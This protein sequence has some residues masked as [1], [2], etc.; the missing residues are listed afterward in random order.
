MTSQQN[1]TQPQANRGNVNASDAVHDEPPPS[2]T[3]IENIPEKRVRRERTVCGGC[4]PEHTAVMTIL[5]MYFFLS[6][7]YAGS[8]AVGI[9]VLTST[10]DRI[11]YAISLGLSV[12][13][14]VTSLIG[15]NV[16]R[17]KKAR[18]LKHLSIAFWVLTAL[19]LTF[20]ASFFITLIVIREKL[21][22]SCVEQAA[23][24]GDF[25]ALPE[26]KLAVNLRIIRDAFSLFFIETLQLYFAYVIF[27]YARYLGRRRPGNDVP[28]D[29][30]RELGEM[31]PTYVVYAARVPTSEDWVP[32]PVYNGN[33]NN[34]PLA[35]R[36]E[37][38]GAS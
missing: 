13:F 19:N 2:Y 5:V 4:L 14:M 12:A 9:S 10:R 25:D 35:G 32:P 29:T 38:A 30:S 27:R 37:A 16:V 6:A 17:K 24:L 26:C 33:P 22:D 20:S 31:P 7:I 28:K 8:A 11:I 36:K 21:V 15:M 1:D 18:A 34:V 3:I 23:E